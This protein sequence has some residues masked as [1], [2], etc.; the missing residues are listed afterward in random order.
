MA[1]VMVV[2]S[3][4]V[5]EKAYGK[6]PKLG[7]VLG[8]DRYV[9]ANKAL[10]PLEGGGKLYC[11]TVRPP[12]ESMWL[13]AILDNPEFDG[14]QWSAQA[15]TVPLTDI[16][17][18][19]SKIKFESG[20]GITANPGALGMSLQTPRTLTAADAALIDAMVPQPHTGKEGFPA[21]P[22][23]DPNTGERRQG[24]ALVQAV[25]DEPD[26]DLARQVYADA[27]QARNDPRGELIVLELALAGPLAIRKREV[28]KARRD[29]LIKAHGAQWFPTELE[30][31]TRGGFIAAISGP[32]GAIAKEAALFASHPIVEAAITHVQGV[33]KLL[34]APWLARIQHLILRGG[35]SGSD[36]AEL[37]AAP[38]TQ[39]LVELNITGCGLVKT[40]L[41]ALKSN[42]PECRT[43][44]LTGNSLGDDGI[45][46]L[47]EWTHLAEVETLYLSNTNL[48][49]A[50]LEKVLAA[51]LPNLTKLTLAKNKL[52]G[53]VG[54]IFAKAAKRL[55][56]LE[57]LELTG[58]A[59]LD[60]TAVEELR[61]AKLPAIRRIDVRQTRI[62]KADVGTSPVFRTNP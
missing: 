36:F 45:A 59:K 62:R 25:I 41:A 49:P 39:Q 8:M 13:V 53:E 24:D 29:Q 57:Y 51:N 37:V 18:L 21:A 48:G 4:A 58:N 16:S 7:T 38:N 61:G 19:R 23:I 2:V 55:P 42:L 12:D 46:K 28:M 5:F 3:K 14:E 47:V 43:L 31:R 54:K 35:L 30:Y 10:S 15:S 1:D 60:A 26:S 44:V 50:G 56:R 40:A 9:T 22:K 33:D 27:L 20:K 32:L 52:G 17:T 6:A 11:V 34:A